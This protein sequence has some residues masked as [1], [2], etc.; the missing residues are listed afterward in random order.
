MVAA[1]KRGHLLYER[2]GCVKYRFYGVAAFILLAVSQQA[3]SEQMSGVEVRYTQLHAAEQAALLL[4]E[5]RRDAIITDEYES[6]FSGLMTKAALE[7][8]TTADLHFLFKAA[9]LPAFYIGSPRYV[10]DVSNVLNALERRNA[11]TSEER[12][13]LYRAF[14]LIRDFASARELLQR[15]SN[16]PVDPIPA[17]SSGFNDP[18]VNAFDFDA[19]ADVLRPLRFDVSRGAHLIVIAHPLCGFSRNAVASIEEDSAFAEVLAARTVWL[20]PVDGSLYLAEFRD[21]NRAHPNV[22]IVQARRKSDWPMIKDWGTPQF[23][24]LRDGE[25][26]A[27]VVGWPKEGR[28]QELLDLLG[29]LRSR[30]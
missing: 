24:A 25:V 18:K 27:H 10:D 6:L 29:V 14:L 22:H 1:C 5:E 23:Y 8:S 17:I 20:A 16:L 2:G 30:K 7:R 13:R 26:V 11:A 28:R 21:W 3:I 12:E 4:Q 15:H 19:D 9:Y